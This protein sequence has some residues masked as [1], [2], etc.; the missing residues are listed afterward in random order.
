MEDEQ[1]N[2]QSC[3]LISG[4]ATSFC[5]EAAIALDGGTPDTKDVTMPLRC[6]LRL[7]P[8]LFAVSPLLSAAVDCGNPLTRQQRVVCATPEL[9]NLDRQL[10]SIY[11]SLL[12]AR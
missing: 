11:K 7:A 12:A 9:V 5:C 6:S 2:N 1:M 3:V 8:I 10:W 4:S